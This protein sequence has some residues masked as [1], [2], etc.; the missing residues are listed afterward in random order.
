MSSPGP[1]GQF[2][3]NGNASGW[4]E[5]VCDLW[6]GGQ[7]PGTHGSA[8]FGGGAA[9]EAFGIDDDALVCAYTDLFDAIEG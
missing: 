8:H 9:H 1:G 7:Q 5:S 3:W 2:C 6:Q 4:Q